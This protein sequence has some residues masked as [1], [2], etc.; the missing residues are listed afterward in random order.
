[1]REV[2]TPYGAV[3]M[4]PFELVLVERLFPAVYPGHR[5]TDYAVA[6]MLAARAF[7]NSD[8]CDWNEVARIA[9][10]PEFGVAREVGIL[11][12]EVS[13]ELAK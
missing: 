6:K 10:L 11:K 13:D 5:E 8:I 12:K 7:A 3:F 1:L 9:A 2:Q 4:A